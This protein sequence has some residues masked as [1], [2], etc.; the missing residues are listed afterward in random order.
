MKALILSIN[1]Q[2]SENPVEIKKAYFSLIVYISFYIAIITLN[3]ILPYNLNVVGI[4][5]LIQTLVCGHLTFKFESHNR[6]VSITLILLGIVI[7]N[8]ADELNRI[9]CESAN[10][11]IMLQIGSHLFFALHYYRT[12]IKSITINRLSFFQRIQ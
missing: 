9:I 10:L 1:Q 5:I 6:L 3:G 8:C 7:I 4:V 2:I 12:I 11:S